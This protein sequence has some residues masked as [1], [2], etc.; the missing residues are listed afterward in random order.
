[1]SLSDKYWSLPAR[2]RR[3]VGWGV[4]VTA[5]VLF[6]LLM[7]GVI[8]GIESLAEWLGEGPLTEAIWKGFPEGK[9]WT[10]RKFELREKHPK[11]TMHLSKDFND[12]NDTQL[13]AAMRLGISPCT[14]REEFEGLLND[15]KLV[16]LENCKYYKL[17][18]LTHSVPYLVPEA[19][20]FLLALGQLFQEYSGTET[21]FIVTSVLRSGSDV[22]SL[23]KGNVNA[24]KNSCHCYGTT[25][26][27]TYN[28]FDHHGAARSDGQLKVD[29]SR[30][31]WDLKNA[32]HCYVKFERKQACFHLTVR[33]R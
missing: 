20:D 1:V 30:A 23:S 29:L 7:W 4:V 16:T 27:I 10:D 9:R 25:I 8:K 31:L 18:R 26:D 14:K 15:G 22:G 5:I 24:T 19:A 28:R 3:A 13:A 33:P 32:G 21:R 17:D 2:Q 6:L 12:I 11:R